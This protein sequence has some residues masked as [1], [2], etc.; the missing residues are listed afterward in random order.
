MNC[1][2]LQ[3]T[4][5][6][7]DVIGELYLPTNDSNVINKYEKLIILCHGIGQDRNYNLF[8]GL[9]EKLSEQDYITFSMELCG[10]GLSQEKF[11]LEC[12]VEQ[13]ETII[14]TLKSRYKTETAI[15]IG[16]S[17]GGVVAANVA[18]LDLIDGYVLISTPY[19]L[20][21]TVEEWLGPTG[22]VVK[23]T[24]DIM[25]KYNIHKLLK[26]PIYQKRLRTTLTE[27]L[28]QITHYRGKVYTFIEKV[29]KPLLIIHG[30]NDK[31]VNLGHALKLYK[32]TSQNS[33]FI[34]LHAD[35]DL[36]PEQDKA[37]K[38][39]SSFITKC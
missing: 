33:K 39:I 16:H 37:I 24:I 1:K 5:K 14:K 4:L 18:S 27:L 22:P 20:S 11:S 32:K 38:E 17:L 36:N 23:K 10:H 29:Q 3:K 26:I 30:I 9:S 25:V 34:I 6:I 12:M 31:I 8:A 28:E 19:D 21:S 15:M 13:A 35:H 7:G 2:S